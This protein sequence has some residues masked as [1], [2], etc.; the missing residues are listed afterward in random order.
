MTRSKLREMLEAR[1]QEFVHG[2]NYEIMYIRVGTQA[3]ANAM[4]DLVSEKARE[5]EAEYSR[6]SAELGDVTIQPITLLDF[7]LARP[8]SILVPC[9]WDARINLLSRAID[10]V[11]DLSKMGCS[12]PSW[13]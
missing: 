3:Q 9:P 7:A 6:L 5:I 8:R 10:N 11:C 4:A 13:S 2:Y 1:G 12:V